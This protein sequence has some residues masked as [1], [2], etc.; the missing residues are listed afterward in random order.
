MQVPER[1]LFSPAPGKAAQAKARLFEAALKV[2]GERGPDGATVR[3]IARA[4]GQ[5][6]ASIAYYFGSKG[7]LYQA[8]VEGIVRT[9]LEG[10]EDRLAEVEQL[11]RSGR[12]DPAAAA[13]LVKLL[14]KTV[15][16]RMLSRDDAVSVVRIV[17]R[18]QLGPTAA[19][20][21]LYGR[22]FKRIHEA[23]CFLFGM[24]VGCDPR[25]RE[26]ILRT[27]ML[28]GQVYFFAMSREAILRRVGWKSLAGKNAEVVASLLENHLD[29]MLQGLAGA[30]REK[31]S[32]KSS[33]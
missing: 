32:L 3:D 6:V 27:H 21:V 16:L 31:G 30:N 14:L 10:L 9:I 1:A 33:L 28:M 7:K 26:T 22:G 2:F 19:F 15:Y 13:Q 11:R 23:L 8:V 25:E 20:D 4:A 18:E 24:A 29:V 12:N 17:V 5:N